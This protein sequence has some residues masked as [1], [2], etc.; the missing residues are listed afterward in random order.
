M[1][2]P[3]GLAIV[4]AGWAGSRHAEAISELDNVDPRI[5]VA[6][7]VDNDT[8]HL[9]KTASKFDVPTTYSTLDAA[10]D[11]PN[12]DAIDIATPHALHEP[13]TIQ[14]VEAGKH[15]IVEKPMAMNVDEAT[16]MIDAAE[17]N[18][19]R[20]FVAANQSYEPYIEFLR[21][22]VETGTPIGSITTASVAA[23]FR[24]RGRYGYPGRREWLAEPNMGGTG[25]WM[26]HGIHTIAG[27][28]QVFGD[29]KRVYVQ[30][31]KTG[32][33]R[34]SDL[35]GTM[36]ALLT[37]ESGVNVSVVQSPETRFSGNTG[38]YM[39]H[40]ES[41]SI[42]ASAESYELITDGEDPAPRPYPPSQLSSYALEFQTFANHIEGDD[43]APTTGYSER[44]TL[45][46]VQAG[47]E[48]AVS[49]NAIDIQERFGSL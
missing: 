1:T 42:R 48:S 43:S 39:L 36:S 34:R 23:G 6:A 49:G 21:R 22:V 25:S 24:P 10:L 32:T 15:V 9:Q 31:H 2:N 44:K 26:L 16:H 4:G 47:A 11:D 27:V 5:K 38:G 19:V 17:S 45:A 46:V 8:E 28:R 3:I 13:M 29:V 20:L 41:G 12:V 18:G 14:A 30:E 7:F 37:V 35:E 40:G 33:F